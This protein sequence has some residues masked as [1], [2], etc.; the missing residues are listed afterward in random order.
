VIKQQARVTQVLE[1]QVEL[2]CALN[3]TCSG[4]S[5]ES[6]CGVGT[7]AK[8]FAGKTQLVRVDTSLILSPGQWVTIGTAEGNLLFQAFI[9]YFFPLFGLLGAGLIGQ[10]LLVDY[11]ELPGYNAILCAFAGGYFCYLVA[12]QAISRLDDHSPNIE[13]I[14]VDY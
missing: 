13:I 8:A 9:T 14:A 1:H 10:F 3:S 2:E 4:C 5:N 7:V 12:K 6:S 11:M